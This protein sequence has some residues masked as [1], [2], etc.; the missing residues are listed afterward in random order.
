MF[1][2]I[3]AIMLLI[4]FTVSAETEVKVAEAVKYYKTVTILSNSNIMRSA[5]MGE[6]SSITTEITE[7]EY[8]NVDTEDD[9][10]PEAI[11]ISPGNSGD[12]Y[13]AETIETNYK[14][15]STEMSAAGSTQYKYQVTLEWKKIPSTR[16]Y[17]IIAIGHYATV[18]KIGEVDLE[19]TYCRSSSDC[20]VTPSYYAYSDTNGV[21]AVFK[22]PSGTLTSLKQVLQINVEK[23]NPVVYSQL[24]AGD[25]AHA[26]SSISYEKAKLF[27][28]DGA[29]IFLD[30]SIE[31]YYDSIS[32]ADARW[33]GTW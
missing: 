29:G 17:D 31:D 2:S 23:V 19:Q 6:I 25:Y 27:T 1:I 14:K 4:P 18:K 16:S 32:T 10:P 33:S 7:E 9:N 12:Y 11:I 28:V 30:S 22:I 20:Y 3:V 24:A 13:T 21:A 8:N 5:N 26:T 15:L